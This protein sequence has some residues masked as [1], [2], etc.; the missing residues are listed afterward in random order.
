MEEGKVDLV[1]PVYLLDGL[2]KYSGMGV[3]GKEK[4]LTMLHRRLPSALPLFRRGAQE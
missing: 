2:K 4:S 3:I 1:V